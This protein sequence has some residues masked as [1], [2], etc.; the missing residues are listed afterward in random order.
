MQRKSKAGKPLDLV[1]IQ[2][3]LEQSPEKRV[4][5]GLDELAGTPEYQDFLACEFPHDPRADARGVSR[6][7]ALKL[8]GASAAL[9]GLTACTKLPTEKIVPSGTPGRRLHLGSPSLRRRRISEPSEGRRCPKRDGTERGECKSGRRHPPA[10]RVPDRGNGMAV[11]DQGDWIAAAGGSR[12]Q[13]RPT[14][15]EAARR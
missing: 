10:Q 12:T 1:Q 7:S 4:W 14:S 13:Q 5:R 8:M 15:P 11:P 3:K 2:A 9:A 6:R